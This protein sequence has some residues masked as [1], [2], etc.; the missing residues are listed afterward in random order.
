MRRLRPENKGECP[1]SVNLD[2]RYRKNVP[3]LWLFF[4]PEFHPR[5]HPPLS[6]ETKIHSETRLL[7]EVV[8][9]LSS[10]L[11]W[12]PEVRGTNP[13]S[14]RHSPPNHTFT[15]KCSPNPAK[16]QCWCWKLEMQRQISP[17]S[18]TGLKRIL[19]KLGSTVLRW[20]ARTHWLVE[21]GIAFAKS[22]NAI[23]SRVTMPCVHWG[24]SADLNLSLSWMRSLKAGL[25]TFSSW[26]L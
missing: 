6:R 22:G 12:L 19:S 7:T 20:A 24:G 13:S 3:F 15:D 11:S 25:V 26:N 10:W 4:T 16:K 2:G 18:V 8:E 23:H 21:S 5:N 17:G 1:K 14:L 9:A